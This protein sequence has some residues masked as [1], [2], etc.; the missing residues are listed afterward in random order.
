[1]SP[2]PQQTHSLPFSV[3]PL[4]QVVQSREGTGTPHCL[5]EILQTVVDQ[6]KHRV[7]RGFQESEAVFGE[8][9]GGEQVCSL[10]VC[11]EEREQLVEDAIEVGEES[12]EKDFLIADQD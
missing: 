5:A 8:E 7:L 10:R 2:P 3:L 6:P 11:F 4:N 9:V 1:M 12:E